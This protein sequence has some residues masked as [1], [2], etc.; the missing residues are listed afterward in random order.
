MVVISHHTGRKR[1]KPN[2]PTTQEV[3]A[4]R[5]HDDGWKAGRERSAKGKDVEGVRSEAEGKKIY[6][7]P[8]K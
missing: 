4:L 5:D 6:R 7:S 8:G 3:V 1:R 2:L